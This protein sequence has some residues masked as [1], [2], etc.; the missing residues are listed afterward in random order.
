MPKSL[1]KSAQAPASRTLKHAMMRLHLKEN[2][3]LTYK[4][5]MLR[6]LQDFRRLLKSRQNNKERKEEL[7]REKDALRAPFQDLLN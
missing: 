3:L 6:R 2:Q 1:S 7:Q 4:E 5:K